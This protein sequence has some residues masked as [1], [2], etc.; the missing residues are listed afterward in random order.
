MKAVLASLILTV[1]SVILGNSLIQI[2]KK[3]G[4]SKQYKELH[5]C[6]A[7]VAFLVSIYLIKLPN[8]WVV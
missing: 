6:I 8:V 5:S 3:E 2:F 1:S 4:T 7:A